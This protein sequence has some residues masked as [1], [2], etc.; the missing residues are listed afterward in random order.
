[1]ELNGRY[2]CSSV[3]ERGGLS[4]G[5]KADGWTK[6]LSRLKAERRERRAKW[7]FGARSTIRKDRVA[8]RF[9]AAY[10]ATHRLYRQ[11]CGPGA[12]AACR[13][14]SEEGGSGIRSEMASDETSRIIGIDYDFRG[15]S[16]SLVGPIAL[17]ALGLARLQLVSG[18]AGERAEVALAGEPGRVAAAA[19]EGGRCAVGLTAGAAA[20]YVGAC[21]RK[22][23]GGTRR[24]TRE[25]MLRR[26]TRAGGALLASR[27]ARLL[28]GSVRAGTRAVATLATAP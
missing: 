14:P 4:E 28:L 8:H 22:S 23:G 3:R 6:L 10:A 15:C 11:G 21:W 27:P 12:P 13:V 24:G 26:P 17:W 5:L 9:R 16:H 19:D 25:G 1:V 18:R 2:R 20:P 7:A